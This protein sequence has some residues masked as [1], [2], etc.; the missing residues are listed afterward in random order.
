MK[1][2]EQGKARPVKLSQKPQ[3]R[4]GTLVNLSLPPNFQLLRW[5][6]F[7]RETRALCLG[8]EQA[9]GLEVRETESE[10]PAGAGSVE[11]PGAASCELGKSAGKWQCV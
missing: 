10:D 8:A 3:G 11:G 5:G 6:H 4:I 1:L 2:E 9:L 7:T